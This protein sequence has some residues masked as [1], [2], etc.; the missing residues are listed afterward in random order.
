MSEPY[1]ELVNVLLT[2]TQSGA[3]EW[4]QADSAGRAF[5]ATRES[6]T[7]LIQSPAG[8]PGMLATVT[9]TIKNAQ[10]DTIDTVQSG[11]MLGG[12][13]S[14]LGG[15][16]MAKG[17]EQLYALVRERETRANATIKALTR[18]FSNGPEGRGSPKRTRT[19]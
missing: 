7:V 18:E 17:L 19:P 11:G 16:P 9:M 3:V 13:I 10:G 2:G 15:F 6:G 12:A 5:I 1:D 4:K 8:Q 14:T